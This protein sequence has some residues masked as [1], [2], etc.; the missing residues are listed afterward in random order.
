MDTIFKIYDAKEELWELYDENYKSI[1]PEDLQWRN[2]AVDEKDGEA[3]T[4]D[5]L[6]NFVNNQLFPTLKT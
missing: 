1:I 5:D 3:L 2:W 4:G 6:L